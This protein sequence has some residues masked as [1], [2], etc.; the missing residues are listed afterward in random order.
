MIYS[1][2][3][4][5]ALNSESTEEWKE[6]MGEHYLDIISDI[7]NTPRAL[8]KVNTDKGIVKTFSI[9]NFI[10]LFSQSKTWQELMEKMHKKYSKR[11]LLDMKNLQWKTV[12]G[13]AEDYQQYYLTT[14]IGIIDTP[15]RST[16]Q[17]ALP[18]YLCLDFKNRRRNPELSVSIPALDNWFSGICSLRKS[19]KR[20]SKDSDCMEN[21][22]CD[23][24][25]F[26][27]SHCVCKYGFI[28]HESGIFG[29]KHECLDCKQT[30]PEHEEV[31]AIENIM[32][33]WV[34]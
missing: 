22:F 30:L 26:G 3:Y 23:V 20:C 13:L 15:Q 17:K 12:F 31:P 5:D 2:K 19:S 1:Q 14:G 21:S 28:V 16:W 25:K 18:S 4:I 34:R 6:K 29:Q 7:Y 33:T 9:K 10:G 24:N 27:K 8:V 11:P 32:I